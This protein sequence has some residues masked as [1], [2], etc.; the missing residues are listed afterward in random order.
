MNE[1]KAAKTNEKKAAKTN[2]YEQ[3]Y[4]LKIKKGEKKAG[5]DFIP[6]FS[7]KLPENFVAGEAS[8]SSSKKAVVES[9]KDVKEFKLSGRILAGTMAGISFRIEF[10]S[11]KG[12]EFLQGMTNYKPSLHGRDSFDKESFNAVLRNFVAGTIGREI[13]CGRGKPQ[14]NVETFRKGMAVWGLDSSPAN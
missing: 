4:S 9:R 11:E 12:I 5:F 2:N 10:D 8:F 7:V 1:K 13:I 3:V 6:L 14:R